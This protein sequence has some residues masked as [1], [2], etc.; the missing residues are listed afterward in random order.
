MNNSMINNQACAR[1]MRQLDLYLDHEAGAASD[2]I[3]QHIAT[4]AACAGEVEARTRLRARLRT[5]VLNSAPAPPFLESRVRNRIRMTPGRSVWVRFAVPVAAVL[6]LCITG[7]VAY[8]LGHLRLT[9][10][11]QESY[12]AKVSNQV[13]TLLRVGLG[14]HVHCAV[15]RKYPKEAP[16]VEKFVS[17]IGPE[18]RGL[19]QIVKDRVPGEFVLHQAHQCRYHGRRFVHMALKSESSVMSLVIAR[20]KD[21]ESFETEGLMPS[22]VQSGIPMYRSGVQRFQLAAFETSA[23]LVYVISDLPREK[24]TEM[25]V[26][27]APEVKQLLASEPPLL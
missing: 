15:F 21:G 12:I 22:L 10:Q 1:A 20:K 26:A 19:I 3:R 7:V 4:C 27:L 13:A 8:E 25:I 9:I 17:E 18:Y 6:G 16:H 23:H 5:A 24:N 11:S 2:D 14:D